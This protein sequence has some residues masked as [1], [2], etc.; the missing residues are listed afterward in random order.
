MANILQSI[1]LPDDLK[2]IKKRDLP[3][4]CEE[5]RERIISVMTKNGGH[6]ASN[7]GVVELTAALHY[8]FDTPN[9]Q[10]IFDVGHQSYTHKILTGRNNNFDT[11]RL[12]DGLSGFTR[13]KESIYDPV[14][15]G[16]SSTSIS[17]AI[18]FALANKLKNINN[19]IAVIIGDGALTGGVAFEGLNFTG[20]RDLP[21]III[22]NDNEMSIGENVGSVS[23]HFAELTLS[24]PYQ[25]LTDIYTNVMK[26]RRG[27]IKFFFW[28]AKNV[29]RVLKLFLGYENIFLNLGF[30]YIGPLDGHNINQLINIFSKIKNNVH[31]P[32]LIHVKTVKGK[33]YGRAENNPSDFHGVTPYQ[34]ANGKSELKDTKSFTDIFSD[35][36][37]KLSE[38]HNNIIGITAAMEEGTGLKK[39]KERFPDKFFDVGIAEQHAVSMASTLAYSGL[40][41]VF[42]VYSTFLQRAIDQVVQDI[43][44]SSAPVIFAIDRAGIVGTD[45]ETHQG[46]FDISFLRMIPNIMILAPSDSTELELMLDYAYSLKTPVAIRYPR[47]IAVESQLDNKHP[48]IETNPFVIVKEGVDVLIIVIGPF[49][50]LAKEVISTME[51]KK[52]SCGILYLRVLKPI[53]D[54]KIYT[55]IA[56]YKKVIVI[57]ENVFSGS[58]SQYI[59]TIV[60]KHSNNIIF[61]SVNIPD[62]FIEHDTRNNILQ[63]IGFNKDYISNKILNMF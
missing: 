53:D 18:G 3:Q 2:K 13:R 9:D 52:L 25:K 42:A 20:H 11:I 39:F 41:P 40:R 32:I 45:G 1:N 16:H 47:D 10:I 24:K 31:R 6:L 55:E 5:I 19:H 60:A 30:E 61:D 26:K 46:Q 21:L 14:D 48:D 62:K 34:M 12:K 63:L 58:V 27:I 49:V 35:K 28:F 4:L 54:E 15:A 7:L 51:D 43:C 57:E 33:G 22:L 38:Q 23:R 59:G 8:V 29:E 56:K 37:V 17:Q 44:I 50:T 36:I